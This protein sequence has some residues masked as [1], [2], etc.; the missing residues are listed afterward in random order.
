M[1][2][3]FCF[4]VVSLIFFQFL[5]TRGKL[6][7]QR[8]LTRALYTYYIHTF[9]HSF[10]MTLCLALCCKAMRDIHGPL[11]TSEPIYANID[12][13]HSRIENHTKEWIALC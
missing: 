9:I 1:L 5:A 10:M 13:H 4:V 3:V 2:T 8:R 7:R 11:Y 12:Y 6:N